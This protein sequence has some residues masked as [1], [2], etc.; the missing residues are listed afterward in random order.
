LLQL[1]GHALQLGSIEARKLVCSERTQ[2]KKFLQQSD[3]TD[4]QAPCLTLLSSLLS[5]F[6]SSFLS[7]LLETFLPCLKNSSRFVALQLLPSVVEH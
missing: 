7:S 5:S 4:L 3:T 2:A 6:L 1:L